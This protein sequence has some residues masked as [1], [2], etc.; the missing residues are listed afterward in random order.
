[1]IIIDFFL[2]YLSHPHETSMLW[3]VLG[4]L[5]TE[6]H[7]HRRKKSCGYREAY[8]LGKW[9]RKRETV[10]WLALFSMEVYFAEMESKGSVGVRKKAHILRG[11]YRKWKLWGWKSGQIWECVWHSGNVDNLFKF[12][13]PEFIVTFIYHII[14]FSLVMLY[15]SFSGFISIKKLWWRALGRIRLMILKMVNCI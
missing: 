5:Y 15:D 9:E 14:S 3:L 7:W 11:I 6:H 4:T 2:S 8:R 1:M 10:C 13:D 12:V